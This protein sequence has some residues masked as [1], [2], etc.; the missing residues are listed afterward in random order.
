MIG[1]MEGIYNIFG[2]KV[3]ESYRGI[4]IKDGRKVLK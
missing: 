1:N 4:N 2:Q 3:G